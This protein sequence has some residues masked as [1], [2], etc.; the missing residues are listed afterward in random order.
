M[1]FFKTIL[2]SLLVLLI[3]GLVFLEVTK[4]IGIPEFSN[5]IETALG[6]DK[7]LHFVTGVIISLFLYRFFSRVYEFQFIKRLILC[8]YF[9]II[10]LFVAELSQ[11]IFPSRT[12]SVYD[13]IAGVFGVLSI[14]IVLCSYQFIIKINNSFN[15][16]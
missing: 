9:S 3:L 7:R 15:R 6:N 1:N 4:D 2:D 11:V 12:Y 8:S 13:I 10:I 14:L 5:L 16:I